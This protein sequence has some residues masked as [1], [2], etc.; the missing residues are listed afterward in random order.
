[1][2]G[3]EVNLAWVVIEQWA[4]GEVKGDELDLLLAPRLEFRGV[5]VELEVVGT[6]IEIKGA[7][8]SLWALMA[9]LEW[10]TCGILVELHC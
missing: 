10:E 1:M 7:L 3:S 9:T 2:E 4:A 8:V 6:K 5:M